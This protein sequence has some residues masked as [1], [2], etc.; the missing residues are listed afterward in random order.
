VSESSRV[1]S[2]GRWDVVVVG[3]GHAGVEAALAARRLQKRVLLVT[4]DTSRIAEM[5]CNPAIGGIAKGT[6]VREIDALGGS[7]A[8]SADETRLQFRMLNRR[9]GRAVWG[10][11]AQSDSPRY[12]AAQADRL[13]GAGV[14][15]LEDEVTALAGRPGETDGV[16]CRHRGAIQG[17]A[18]V[19]APGTFLGGVLFRGEETW[20]GGRLGDS[21]STALDCFLRE[22]EF[23]VERFKTGTSPRLLRRSIDFD[24]MERQEDHGEDYRFAFRERALGQRGEPCYTTRTGRKTRQLALDSLE[25]SPLYTGRI[26]G[27]G[28]RYCPSF[29]D[30]AVRFPDRTEH[31]IFV[32]PV[33]AESRDM[34]LNGLST[35]LPT[36][37]QERIVRSIAGL[38]RAEISA[39]G[40]AVEYSYL[41]GGE[42]DS[43]L[44]L[45]GE[46]SVFVAG[47]ICGTSGYEEAAGLGLLAGVNAA[48]ASMGMDQVSLERN[49]SYLGV[50][51]DDLTGKSWSEPYRLFSSRAENRLH[52]REQNADLRLVGTASEWGIAREEDIERVE[53]LTRDM[54]TARELL[55]SVREGVTG[56]VHCRRPETTVERLLD[57]YPDLK[58]IDRRA[59]EG[60]LLDER[61]GGYIDRAIRR[62]D[63][64]ARLSGVRIDGIADFG[65]VSEISWEAR[66]LLNRKRP[67]TLGEAAGLVGVR[68][69]DIDGLL[70]FLARGDCST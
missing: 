30:K 34:Y 26:D 10:P 21:S 70:L 52:I 46:R 12:A 47:Q 5:S 2:W 23:H 48:R 68:P 65:S 42:F 35:S 44:R 67:A 61:Y 64:R 3:G 43:C 1:A 39:P 8:E 63:L 59:M 24:R 25:K 22:R 55:G 4:T 27:V 57:M 49:D 50:M 38:E 62:T 20:K 32:E 31:L 7:M 40:Y 18:V 41:R 6:L 19:L 16:V 13:L 14:V 15:V 56:I 29:E 51:V 37:V 17:S 36:S 33:G 11:R 9:K 60:V 54:K 28:P 58:T 45:R 66:E 69:S 53:R